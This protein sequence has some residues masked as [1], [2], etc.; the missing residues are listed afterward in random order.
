M[1][2]QCRMC[3]LHIPDGVTSCM[4]CGNKNLVPATAGETIV[5][6]LG[7]QA[8]AKAPGQAS[9]SR[10]LWAVAISLIVTPVI[11]VL[12]IVNNE[13]PRLNSDEFQPYLQSHPGMTNLLYFE[14]GMN[15]FLV[16]SALAL[17]FLFY[18]KRKMFPMLMVVYIA[19]TVLFRVAVV[20]ML[21]SM[22]PDANLSASYI[23]IVRYLIFAGA[24]IPYLLTSN[25][26]K[27]RFV[28]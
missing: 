3:G 11:R 22:F 9:F 7:T 5:P 6:S 8:T 18:T 19:L 4:M 24:M 14:I 2:T 15:A 12:A 17:N 16:I 21:N 1:A 25:E 10:W 23:T 13:L 27:K 28:K 26:I 20:G